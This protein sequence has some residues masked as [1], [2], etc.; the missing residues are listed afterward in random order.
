MVRIDQA[1]FR[2]GEEHGAVVEFAAVR[3]SVSVR[4]EMHQRHFTKM[5]GMGAQQRQRNKVVTAERE[6]TLTGSQ[7]FFCVGLQLFTHFTRIAEGVHQVAAVHHVQALAH[8]EVPR[9]AVM[10]PGQ[11]SGNLADSCRAV[12]ATGATGGRH[13]KRHAGDH[14]V[15]ITVV[16]LEVHWKA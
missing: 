4:I 12:A 7:Q 11:V 10:L 2:R 5:L 1:F 9:E 16:R 8:V 13:I 3:V 15:R 14:P 6:H